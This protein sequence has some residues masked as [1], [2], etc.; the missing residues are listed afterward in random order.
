[1]KKTNKKTAKRKL[2]LCNTS[3]DKIDLFVVISSERNNRRK[4]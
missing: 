2:Y 1:L 3:F 4:T